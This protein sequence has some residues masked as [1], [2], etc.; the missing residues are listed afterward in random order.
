MRKLGHMAVIGSGASA[1]YLLNQ[2]SARLSTLAAVVDSITILEKSSLA[3]CGMP[4]NPET[5]DVYNMSNISSEEIPELPETYYD[6]L[7]D[8]APRELRAWKMDPDCI[9]ESEVYPRLPLGAYLHAQYQAIVTKLREGGIPVLEKT[10]CNVTDISLD[11]SADKLHIESSERDR[12]T[13]D[14]VV[15]ATGHTWSE[16]DDAENGYFGSPWPIFKILPEEGAFHNYRIGT[17]GAS[18][19]AFDVI[20]SLA[21]R[22]GEFREGESGMNYHPFP[23]TEDFQLTM[24]AANGWLPHLQFDQD[25]PFRIIYR[26]V[27]REKMLAIRDPEGRLRIAD[28]FDEVCRPAL[29]KAFSKDGLTDVV[30][31]LNSRSFSLEEFVELMSERHE[32]EDA[33]MGMRKEMSEA[34]ESVEDHKPI[35]WKEV[36]DDLMFT[37]NFHAELMPAEDHLIFRKTMMPFLMNVIAAMPLPSAEML[38]ALHDAG[39]LEL[40]AGRVAIADGGRSDGTTTITVEDD[41]GNSNEIQYGMFVDCSGQKPLE[42]D[43][44]PFQSLVAS[45]KVRRARA[46]FVSG[47][48]YRKMVREGEG[49]HLFEEDSEYFL[50]TGGVDVDAAFRIIG[51][52]GEPESAVFDLAFP[53]TSGVRPYSYGL[54]ACNAT[55]EIIVGAWVEAIKGGAGIE[56][57]LEETTERYVSI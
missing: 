21:H 37:L 36:I 26:H 33:F 52:G 45:G 44:Y 19:S 5:T 55:A 48:I 25:E 16:D 56:G 43:Q 1:I 7:C 35:Y 42:L 10:L 40:I 47:D 22:H 39:K 32:Y 46:T 18:L 6:W 38:L 27:S 51:R 41:D 3:G 14:S 49:E 28:Y 15:I 31:K 8:R 57:D 12:M 50:H 13:F 23:G 24:H 29:I 30:R 4:Y 20:S 54:Q 11:T 9:S 34:K 17:L 2:I 53:H